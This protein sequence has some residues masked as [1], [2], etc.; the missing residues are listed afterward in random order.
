MKSL[1]L[2][3]ASGLVGAPLWAVPVHAFG[4]VG[5]KNPSL[6][7]T[8]NVAGGYDDNVSKQL[9]SAESAFISTDIGASLAITMLL[10]SMPFSQLGGIF[11]QRPEG[12]TNESLSNSTL[13]ASLSH[14]FDRTL[15]QRQFSFTWQPEPNY[16]NGIANPP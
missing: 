16:S 9:Q 6:K 8:F 15:L 1:Y 2:S 5:L 10:P 12:D 4:P 11:T 7:W 13:T 14:S 3:F